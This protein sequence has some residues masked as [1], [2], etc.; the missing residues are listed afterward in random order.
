MQVPDVE[1]LRAE[2]VTYFF[3]KVKIRVL[4]ARPKAS[5]L[6]VTVRK[7]KY[8][9][10]PQKEFIYRGSRSRL[11]DTFKKYITGAQL[12]WDRDDW[13]LLKQIARDGGRRSLSRVSWYI[14]RSTGSVEASGETSFGLTTGKLAAAIFIIDN[15]DELFEATA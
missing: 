6:T 10:W 12:P 1:V 13:E 11:I 5:R 15:F 9:K 14:P 3:G 7:P 8:K 4:Y 2:L